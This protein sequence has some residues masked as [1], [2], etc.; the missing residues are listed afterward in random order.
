MKKII[1]KVIIC[2]CLLMLSFLYCFHLIFG[3]NN[4]RF[5]TEHNSLLGYNPDIKKTF[6][7]EM[8]VKEEDFPKITLSNIFNNYIT[9]LAIGTA[10]LYMSRASLYEEVKR[11]GVDA[12]IKNE[13]LTEKKINKNFAHIFHN[14]FYVLVKKKSHSKSLYLTLAL[15]ALCAILYLIYLNKDLTYTV[16]EG[17][18]LIAFVGIIVS[19]SI[20]FISRMNFKGDI[21]A[22]LLNMLFKEGLSHI[23]SL[24]PFYFIIA[25]ILFAIYLVTK[26]SKDVEIKAME[27]RHKQDFYG[28]EEI[29][30]KKFDKIMESKLVLIKKPNEGYII[31]N[32]HSLYKYE[33]V[34]VKEN[35]TLEDKVYIFKYSDKI[36]LDKLALT[37]KDIDLSDKEEKDYLIDIDLKD[38]KKLVYNKRAYEEIADVFE[39]NNI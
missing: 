2:F 1:T 13:S 4:I 23:T 11:T 15:I 37:L 10:P 7:Q 14:D 28:D 21:L 19:T 25:I 16:Y 33:I 31:D 9:S 36:D 22:F 20:F 34:Y 24:L 39:E 32:K 18:Y 6:L 5:V 38:I 26:N 8:E 27:Y 35:N 17:A 30:S 3:D 29:I 12:K